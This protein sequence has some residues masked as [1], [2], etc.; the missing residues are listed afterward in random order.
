MSEKNKFD[1]QLLI[2]TMQ[3]EDLSFLDRMFPFHD[4]KKLNIL[5]V[6]QT[7]LKKKLQSNLQNIQ[8]INSNEFGLS[9]SRNLALQ[10]A[11]SAI[12]LLADDDVI[13]LKFFEKIIHKAYQDYPEA[14][15]IC[16]QFFDENGEFKKK[17]PLKKGYISPKKL[18]LS[19]VEM[20]LNLNLIRKYGLKFNEHFGLGATFPMHE[21]QVF[22]EQLS[23][24]KLKVAFIPAPI[25]IHPG[26]TSA[27]NQA[28]TS[29]VASLAASKFL[30]YGNFV[31]VWL[32]KFI[33]YLCRKK[34][35]QLKDVFSTYSIGI[36]S[37]N[38]M[39]NVQS[40]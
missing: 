37:V 25:L 36:K 31:Y 3:Q 24:H 5:I 13:Y 8:I 34:H 1:F 15:M 38:K 10:H 7:N 12:V 21:E 17:Y 6:N 11:T 32:I 29:F 30:K 2:S 4:W 40:S 28:S 33:F 18:A 16:F 19:S 39:K 22:K 35:I 20:S 14:A 23:S 26:T 27:H 9:K